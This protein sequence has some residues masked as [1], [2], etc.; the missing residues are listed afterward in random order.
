V[1][2]KIFEEKKDDKV[3][4]TTKLLLPALHKTSNVHIVNP[5]A[6]KKGCWKGNGHNLY[7]MFS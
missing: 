2:Q 6:N 3:G 1:E 7:E 5:K 4:L